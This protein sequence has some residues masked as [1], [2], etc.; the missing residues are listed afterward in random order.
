MTLSQV[1]ATIRSSIFIGVELGIRILS[2]FVV[3][4]RWENKGWLMAI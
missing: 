3:E 1:T 4:H 2:V